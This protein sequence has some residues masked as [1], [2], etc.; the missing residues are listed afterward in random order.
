ME[1]TKLSSRMD[2]AAKCKILLYQMINHGQW[3]FSRKQVVR[4]SEVASLLEVS[5]QC[6][7]RLTVIPKYTIKCAC[8]HVPYLG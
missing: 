5:K 4:V 6:H 1:L 7:G 2:F 3:D 8:M